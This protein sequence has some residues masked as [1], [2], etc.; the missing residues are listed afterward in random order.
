MG[1]AK[2]R[3]ARTERIAKAMGLKE[4]SLSEIKKELGLDEDASF[5]GYAIHLESSDEFLAEFQDVENGLV[6]KKVWAKTPEVALTYDELSQA[7]DVSKQCQC[8]VIVVMFDTGEKIMVYPLG[9]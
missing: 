2:Q 5:L 1:Q 3:G 8:S 7:Y 6:V 4:R 9:G